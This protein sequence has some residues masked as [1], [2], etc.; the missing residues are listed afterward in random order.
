MEE[1]DEEVDLRSDEEKKA[2]TERKVKEEAAAAEEKAAAAVVEEKKVGVAEGGETQEMRVERAY[3]WHTVLVT[4]TEI[5][6]SEVAPPSLAVPLPYGTIAEW[7]PGG[8][9]LLRFLLVKGSTAGQV[10]VTALPGRE[11]HVSLRRCL[12]E[13]WKGLMAG[14]EGVDL[15][16]AL[17]VSEEVEGEVRF[18]PVDEGRLCH[19]QTVRKMLNLTN[20][21]RFF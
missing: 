18:L 3:Q 20:V 12:Y 16:S 4:L 15:A 21:F 9:R 11:S 13:H 1:E 10:D 17:D 19:Q 5:E 7:I 6:G 8:H 2:E 14:V